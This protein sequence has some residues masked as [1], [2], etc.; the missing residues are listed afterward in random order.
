MYGSP[1]FDVCITIICHPH[2][3]YAI[4][5]NV[6]VN[7]NSCLLYSVSQKVAPLKLFF[8]IFTS[9]EPI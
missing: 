4:L 6:N 7:V 3:N 1:L 5:A 8:D 2:K 9:G